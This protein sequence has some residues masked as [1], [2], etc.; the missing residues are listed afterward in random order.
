MKGKDLRDYSGF[1]HDSP[2]PGESEQNDTCVMTMMRLETKRY[3]LFSFDLNNLH[4]N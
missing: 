3:Q 4:S 1:L 2:K